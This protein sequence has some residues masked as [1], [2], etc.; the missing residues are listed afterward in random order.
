VVEFYGANKNL[1]RS[2]QRLQ[3]SCRQAERVYLVFM[4][5]SLGGLKLH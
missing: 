3:D 4:E 2:L 5:L 1:A